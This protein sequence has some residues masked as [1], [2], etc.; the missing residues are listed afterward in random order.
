[1][2]STRVCKKFCEIWCSQSKD[3]CF[4]GINCKCVV[5]FW[6]N[7]VMWRAKKNQQNT[8]RSLASPKSELFLNS[9]SI[10]LVSRWRGWWRWVSPEW[11]LR[12]LSEHPTMTSTWPPTSC[13]STEAERHRAERR[14][15]ETETELQRLENTTHGHWKNKV[16]SGAC[17][18]T[19]SQTALW[20]GGEKPLKLLLLFPANFSRIEPRWW[21]RTAQCYLRSRVLWPRCPSTAFSTAHSY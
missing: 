13:S 4:V 1:M 21:R 10:L 17:A 9:A 7:L 12:K 20:L 16:L 5:L 8:L 15:E 19:S 2:I 11:M 18:V 6:V 14:A 3:H